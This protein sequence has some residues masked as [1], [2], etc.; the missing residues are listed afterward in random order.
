MTSR[1]LLPLAV[2]GLLAA[3]GCRAPETPAERTAR[4]TR[5]LLVVDGHVDLP[6]RIYEHPDVDVA[7]RSEEG[8]FDLPRA[9]EGGLKAAFMAI[10]VPASL[11]DAPGGRARADAMIDRVE[12]AVARHPDLFAL[13]RSPGELRGAVSAGRFGWL[14]GIE[15]GAA[16]ENDL[17]ALRHFRQS[18]VAYVTLCHSGN[19]RIADSSF[20]EDRRWHGLSPFGRDVVAEMNRLGMMIDI[21]HASDEAAQQ[22]LALSRAPVIASHSACRHFTPGFER[23]ISDELLRQV[24][25]KGGVVMIA[26]GSMFLSAAAQ[27]QAMQGWDDLDRFRTEHGLNWDDPAMRAYSDEYRR[28]HPPVA[29]SVKDVADH[30]EHAV[31]LAG[32]DAVGLG[33]DFEGV[34]RKPDGLPD[35]SG[36]RNVVRELVDRGW[37]DEDL[38]KVCGENLLRTWEHVLATAAN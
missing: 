5:E 15:N 9:R 36:Y 13:A 2:A 23:N 17:A 14:L 24:A 11:D 6:S 7:V 18:G 28:A 34:D 33:S 31:R 20:A 37:S 30:I 8:D 4:L 25:A 29:T 22:V 10:Y 27:Q 38:R 21:S 1:A 16:I 35:V 26:F 3:A 32:V 12:S 19:N